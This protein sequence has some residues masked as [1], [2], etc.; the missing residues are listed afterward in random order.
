MRHLL[1]P[2]F[3]F[4]CVKSFAAPGDLKSYKELTAL[5]EAKVNAVIEQECSNWPPQPKSKLNGKS[6]RVFAVQYE[7]TDIDGNPTIASGAV[8]LP[9]TG[10]GPYA[11]VSYQ[12]G[13][14]TDHNNVPSR[15][16]GEGVAAGACYGSQN[17]VVV[18]ADYLGYGDS[19]LV[20]PYLHVRT[21]ASASADMLRAAR[22]LAP[23]LGVTFSSKL[24]LAG[25][26]QG[27]GATMALHKY[28]QENLSSEFKVTASTPMAG[29]YDLENTFLT[30][31]KNPVTHSTTEFSYFV[32]TLNSV[33][34]FAPALT[35]IV[36][37]PWAG[38]LAGLFDGT[39]TLD[40]IAAALPQDFSSFIVPSFKKQ[41]VGNPQSAFRQALRANNV[42]NWVPKSPMLLLQGA[43]DKE[44]PTDNTTKTCAA[45]KKA[46]APVD[47]YLIPGMDHPFG[48]ISALPISIDYFNSFMPELKTQR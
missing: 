41:A 3:V 26:S 10:T 47:C 12:H 36:E 45:M 29:P 20:H 23:K 8:F 33:Y 27:G 40:S 9:D 5:P 31:V 7:T 28:L 13:T 43:V 42:N 1:L 4:A 22:Q 39:H 19:Q 34:H 35:E 11:V 25:Y 18:M 46:G 44:V 24:F 32:W 17:N 14:V 21:E 30:V 48:F 15:E 6:L 2:I 37:Q 38:D 16:N